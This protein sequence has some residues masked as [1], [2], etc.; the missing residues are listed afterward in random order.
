M[1]V[2]KSYLKQSFFA[3]F[4][5]NI[6]I[7]FLSKTFFYDFE[8]EIKLYQL[9]RSN[10]R[11]NKKTVDF[12]PGFPCCGFSLYKILR[13][14]GCRMTNALNQNADLLVRWELGTYMQPMSCK[15]KV[16]NGDC[17]D[18]SKERVDKIFKEVFGYSSFVN[19]ATFIGLCVKKSNN[20]ATHDGHIL[21]CP[22]DSVEDGYVYQRLI[23]TQV[24]DEFV[25]DIRVPII[26][27]SIPCVLF[28]YRRIVDQFNNI[29]KAELHNTYEVFS[30][31]EIN[32]ISIFANKMNLDYGELDILRDR[33]D[34]RLYIIDCNTTP[35]GRSY[36]SDK[37]WKDYFSILA[38]SFYNEFL[39]K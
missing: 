22:N 38:D 1:S 25:R 26:G 10:R 19:P 20:N 12:F 31:D 3:L 29:R 11:R 27:R 33:D 8:C 17:L 7:S 24:D 39:C 35:F 13:V 32:M 28:K 4:V 5:H 36:L 15:T 2:V 14:L 34:G 21:H 6:W 23:D 16:L 37:D 9:R 30:S 18:I